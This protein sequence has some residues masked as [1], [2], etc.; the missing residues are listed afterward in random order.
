[1]VCQSIER[2]SWVCRF[3]FSVGCAT[4]A[5]QLQRRQQMQRAIATCQHVSAAVPALQFSC[6]A[7][8]GNRSYRNLYRN[9]VMQ[10]YSC[11]LVQ[12]FDETIPR[13]KQY[14]EAAP[15]AEVTPVAPAIVFETLDM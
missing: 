3:T 11:V 12:R 9:L 13:M 5:G 8:A 4:K 6:S 2:C 15:S 10:S 1:M 14:H 7:S